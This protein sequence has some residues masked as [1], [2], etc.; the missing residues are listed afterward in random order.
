MYI[1]DAKLTR[2]KGRNEHKDSRDATN[3]T[4]VVKNAE[5]FVDS[6]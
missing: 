2:G 6:P 3:G 4:G 1:F 5:E